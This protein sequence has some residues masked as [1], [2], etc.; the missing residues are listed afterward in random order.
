[1]SKKQLISKT[2]QTG[3][4][5][6]CGVGIGLEYQTQ[7]GVKR[8]GYL[9]CGSCNKDFRKRGSITLGNQGKTTLLTDGRIILAKVER[10]KNDK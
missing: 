9:L 5:T 1:M 6:A 8:Y 2:A 4:C 3:E 7:T 10:D